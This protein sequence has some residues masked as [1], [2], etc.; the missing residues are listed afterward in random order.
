MLTGSLFSSSSRP[1]LVIVDAR[2]GPTEYGDDAVEGLDVDVTIPLQALVNNSQ[3]YIPGGR[4][5]VS[6][7]PPLFV[8]FHFGCFSPVRG[9]YRSGADRGFSINGLLMSASVAGALRWI[10]LRISACPFRA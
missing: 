7:G 5:K 9:D 10:T 8:S 1:G 6:S 4:S 3:L 2:Y